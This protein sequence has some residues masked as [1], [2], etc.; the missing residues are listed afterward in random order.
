MSE[1]ADSDYDFGTCCP[2]CGGRVKSN[3]WDGRCRRCGTGEADYD[4]ERV[5]VACAKLHKRA[6]EIRAR[7][8]R[9]NPDMV[10]QIAR[11]VAWRRRDW[12]ER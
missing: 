10:A 2:E 9:N 12:V 11:A 3:E 8:E 5:R 6:D 4:I 1:H 7:W